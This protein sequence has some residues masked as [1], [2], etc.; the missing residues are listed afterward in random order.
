MNVVSRQRSF[1]AGVPDLVVLVGPTAA[2]KSALAVALARE[3]DGEI[4]NA[5]AHAM[6]RGLDI[7][8]AKPTSA[9]RALVPHHCVDLWDLRDTASVAEFQQLGRAAVD[10]ILDRGG[11]PI[12]TGGSALYVRAL[13]DE[14]DIPGTDPDVRARLTAEAEKLGAEAMA[15]R[16]A[17]LDPQAAAAIDP[18]N[19]RRVIRA[20]EVVEL[21]GRFSARMPEGRAWRPA[22]WIGL[23]I[24]RQV[25]DERIEQR[26]ERMWEQGL[27]AETEGLLAAGLADAPTAARAIGYAQATAVLRGDLSEAEARA[28]IVRLTRKLARRQQRNFRQ[29]E[30][31]A[32]IPALPAH[33][34]IDAARELLAP[35]YASR[36]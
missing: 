30:R 25:L 12:V 31:I 6:V 35:Y 28:E 10:D 20:L 36:R 5:D 11:V 22:L 33:A 19:L 16:L 34:A 2:G 21:D 27:L 17:E 24:D 32:W 8:T 14:L 4:V 3:L 7:G 18:R 26:T 29:D 15:E 9:E 23:D 13:A 1:G